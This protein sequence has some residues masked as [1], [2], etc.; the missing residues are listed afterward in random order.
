VW[1]H[2]ITGARNSLTSGV[3]IVKKSRLGVQLEFTLG[4]VL[5]FVL[6]PDI[7]YDVCCYT[8]LSIG[9]R[10]F[11]VDML[12]KLGHYNTDV[13]IPLNKGWVLPDAPLKQVSISEISIF[14]C[15][16]LHPEECFLQDAY[17]SLRYTCSVP[18]A[19]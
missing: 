3:F 4:K 6:T 13:C 1:V 2:L 5:L 7:F 11:K 12:F 16:T 19:H 17:L 15:K 9:P 14:L 18:R 8:V 10:D